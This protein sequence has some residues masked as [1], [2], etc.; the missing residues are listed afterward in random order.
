MEYKYIK[1]GLNS[2]R[3]VVTTGNMYLPTING[4]FGVMIPS[5]PR[6][7]SLSGKVENEKEN[8]LQYRTK[9]LN[10]LPAVSAPPYQKI[11]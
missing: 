8:F 2:R 4:I 9:M 7:Y 3:A 10:T 1:S 11:I 6:Q 5:T